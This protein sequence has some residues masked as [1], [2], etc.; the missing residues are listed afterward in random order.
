M[1]ISPAGPRARFEQGRQGARLRSSMPG[2]HCSTCMAEGRLGRG[3]LHAQTRRAGLYL[4]PTI[5]SV[6]VLTANKASKRL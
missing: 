4:V 6:V 5:A 2:S 1:M 3:M